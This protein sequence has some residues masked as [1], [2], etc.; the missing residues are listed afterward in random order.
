V[1]NAAATGSVIL[2]GGV[3]K[4]RRIG[5]LHAAPQLPQPLAIAAPAAGD[6]PLAD[7]SQERVDVVSRVEM[8]LITNNGFVI[9]N[10]YFF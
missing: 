5:K 4:S 8:K 7:G 10:L 2:E 1:S 9:R 3:R 6:H